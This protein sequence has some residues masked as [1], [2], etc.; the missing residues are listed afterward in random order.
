MF[1]GA[2]FRP[3]F[4]LPEEVGALAHAPLGIFSNLAL[5][6]E[7]LGERGFATTP[8]WEGGPSTPAPAMYEGGSLAGKDSSTAS[9]TS[10]SIF[11]VA[12]V[13]A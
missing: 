4:L 12:M 13:R 8:S 2:P 7:K 11:F 6:A 5:G 9:S 3:T 1:V 10:A